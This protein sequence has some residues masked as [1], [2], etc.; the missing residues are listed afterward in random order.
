M[1]SSTCKIRQYLAFLRRMVKGTMGIN[2]GKE[3]SYPQ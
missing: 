1:Q 3:D 2:A